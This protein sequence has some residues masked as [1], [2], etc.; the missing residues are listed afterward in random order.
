M[1]NNSVEVSVGQDLTPIIEGI[2]RNGEPGVIWM[3]VTRKYG[4]LSDPENNKDWRA[5]GY[6]PCAE[7]S[8]ESMECCTLVETYINRHDSLDD[9]KRTLNFA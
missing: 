2:A 3:D 9:F 6:N 5:A 7:Q 4:R 1:S 8:L